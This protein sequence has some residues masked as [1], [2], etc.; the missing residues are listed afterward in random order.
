VLT[1]LSLLA[2]GSKPWGFESERA[3]DAN[4]VARMTQF[5]EAK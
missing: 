1:E 2:S 3:L 4:A 5:V